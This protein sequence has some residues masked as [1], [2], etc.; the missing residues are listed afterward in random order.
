[1]NNGPRRQSP[2]ALHP[3]GGVLKTRVQGRLAQSVEHLVYTER[4]GGSS[5]SPPTNKNNDLINP[6]S[7]SLRR[8]FAAGNS[9]GNMELPRRPLS[10]AGIQPDA[11]NGAALS[12][13]VRRLGAPVCANSTP[14][15]L[16]YLPSAILAPKL[17]PKMSSRRAL[18]LNCQR[19]RLG[20]GCGAKRLLSFLPAKPLPPDLSSLLECMSW[21]ERLGRYLPR[22]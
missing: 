4:V 12:R 6:F 20:L 16:K 3:H 13:C 22:S 19:L 8:A 1:V 15:S 5:P 14:M 10:W 18:G 21:H 9:G 11:A 2:T 7:S 17:V